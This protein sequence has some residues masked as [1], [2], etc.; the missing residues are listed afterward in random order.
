MLRAFAADA[1]R[2][3][4]MKTR[5]ART[6]GG[7]TIPFGMEADSPLEFPECYFTGAG[8]GGVTGFRVS[9]SCFSR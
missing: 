5:P 1:E 9:A 4:A 6:Q 3:T 2:K 7:W 8:A